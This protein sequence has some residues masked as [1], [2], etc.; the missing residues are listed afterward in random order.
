MRDCK[1]EETGVPDGLKS[2]AAATADPPVKR[3]RGRPPKGSKLA[4]ERSGNAE[5]PLKKKKSRTV[6]PNQALPVDPWATV[7]KRAAASAAM[8]LVQKVVE[9]EDSDNN[10]EFEE[11]DGENETS[12]LTECSTSRDSSVIPQSR[13]RS[14]SER[15]VLPKAIPLD[16]SH[17]RRTAPAMM[18]DVK[19]ERLFGLEH[20]PIFYPTI[21][22][23][24]Q[25]L[26]YIERI[27]KQSRDY[28]YG[29]CKVV[30]PEGWHPPF[31]LNEEVSSVVAH[32]VRLSTDARIAHSFIRHSASG[33]ACSA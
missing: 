25:P 3:K 4:G 5:P 13:S 29:I 6:A 28:D 19:R 31:S 15:K 18:P 17:I 10:S 14:A 27:A 22:E 24:A 23:F 26:E 2:V 16:Y 11:S 33:P 12:D 7:V 9:V 20:C 30:P 8:A 32:S 21:E 1:I